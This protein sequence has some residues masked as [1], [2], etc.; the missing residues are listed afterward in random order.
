MRRRYEPQYQGWKKVWWEELQRELEYHTDETVI[1][2]TKRRYRNGE[3]VLRQ[4]LRDKRFFRIDLLKALNSSWDFRKLNCIA[5]KCEVNDNA[6]VVI[7][8]PC[9]YKILFL[10]NKFVLRKV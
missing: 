3:V 2:L 9:W 10:L 4:N 7:K 8:K 5:I 1:E 6:I